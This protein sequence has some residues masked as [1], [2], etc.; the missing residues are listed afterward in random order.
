M[1]TKCSASTKAPVDAP[2]KQ[3][4]VLAIAEKVKLLDMLKE[5]KSYAAIGRHYGINESSVRNFGVEISSPLQAGSTPSKDA[6]CFL[7][8]FLID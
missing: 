4:E 7:V 1:S 8:F 5:S 2:K 3:R 6:P